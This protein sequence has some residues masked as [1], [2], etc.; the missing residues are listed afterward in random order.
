MNESLKWDGNLYNK[1]SKLQFE[2]GMLGIERLRDQQFNN[3]LEM[4]S[5]N[6]L[7]T[8]ELAKKYPNSQIIAIDISEDQIQ[9]GM[10]NITS[11]NIQNI[12]VI[13]MDALD[14]TFENEF[15]L[16]Y[17]NS[18]IH[19]IQD[20][21]KM[22]QR[23]YTS[24][25]PG[26]KI[27]VQS[28]LKVK[29]EYGKNIQLFIRLMQS[30]EFRP[31]FKNLTLPWRFMTKDENNE[32]LEN[33]KFRNIH[34]EHYDHYFTFKNEGELVDYYKAAGLVPF[35]SVVPEELHENLLQK[36]KEIWYDISKKNPL[37]VYTSRAFLS[38]EK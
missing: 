18:A 12:K 26:G 32:I 5:G 19:W 30:K 4:G 17:A 25:K 8:I 36:F 33:S 13:K 2:L 7:L 28:G 35:M 1:S 14:M 34:V 24:L 37:E 38:A 31:Y 6:A 21:E 23:I 15:D 29:G 22:Y 10:E 9:L 20:L 11:Q 27:M 3:I 16:F